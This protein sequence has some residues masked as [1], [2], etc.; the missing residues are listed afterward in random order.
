[1]EQD[2]QARGGRKDP[3]LVSFSLERVRG[4]V[5]L[6]VRRKTTLGVFRDPGVGGEEPEEREGILGPVV[7]RTFSHLGQRSVC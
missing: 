7:L 4:I 2:H 5:T 6:P 3:P 1:M